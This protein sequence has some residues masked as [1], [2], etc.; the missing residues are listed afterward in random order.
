MALL[1]VLSPVTSI[2]PNTAIVLPLA[3]VPLAVPSLMVPPSMVTP[4]SVNVVPSSTW[5][6]A[7]LAVSVKVVPVTVSLSSVSVT[8]LPTVTPP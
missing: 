3:T 8:P 6:I 2:S 4:D 5:M 7:P 1:I